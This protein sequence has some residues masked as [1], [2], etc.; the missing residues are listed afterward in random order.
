MR[1]K[2]KTGFIILLFQAFASPVFAQSKDSWVAFW[3]QDSM[4]IGFKDSTG[5]I[6][7]QPKFTGF[8]I[9]NKFDNIIAASEELDGTFISYY[10][11]KEGRTIMRDSLFFYD[12]TPDC[13][14]EG[15]IRF[16][17]S[18]TDK[19]GLLNGRGD[20]VIPAEYDGLSK[21]R[22][23]MVT[24]LKGAK[25][26]YWARHKHSGC[27]HY[28]WVGGKKVL[29]TVENR[30][31]IEHSF[32]SENLNLASLTVLQNQQSDS[33]RKSFKGNDEKYY[34]FIDYDL[35]FQLWFKN[36]FLKW[37]TIDSLTKNFFPE[38]A[39]WKKSEGWVNE[40]NHDFVKVNFDLIKS[41][42]KTI[43]DS[44][45]K[46]TISNSGL[47]KFIFNTALYEKFYDNCGDAKDWQ[48]PVKIVSVNY[49]SSNGFNQDRFEFLRTDEGYK[50]ISVSI[51][52]L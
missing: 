16:R 40:S 5:N 49:K 14:S 46:H 37:L 45:S 6:R 51:D 29:L 21:V 19:V 43:S 47:N 31:L 1:S 22:N 42:L 52:E 34:S 26:K 50:L 36:I 4:R 17:A 44:S 12:N 11:T 10:V 35:E 7:I 15:Y 39:Y 32:Y 38:I 30:V 20:V 2:M 23:G 13:E 3:N 25:K 28:S 9:A 18:K 33:I 27:N 48:Y 41:K 8:T 24:G